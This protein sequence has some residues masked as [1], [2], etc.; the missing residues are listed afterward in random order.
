MGRLLTR[1]RACGD[2]DGNRDYG[3]VYVDVDWDMSGRIPCNR[4]MKRFPE[5]VVCTHGLTS[6]VI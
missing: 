3:T 5:G 1:Q 6:E 4:A 2:S